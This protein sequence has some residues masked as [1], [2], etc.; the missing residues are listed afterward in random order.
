MTAPYSSTC[1]GTT[2]TYYISPCV[3]VELGWGGGV[4]GCGS[5]LCIM[6]ELS[7]YMVEEY[8]PGSPKVDG[9]EIT[10]IQRL[11]K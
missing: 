1:I 4:G 11:F 6:L 7:K 2:P 8:S 9:P 5:F 3:D 10:H